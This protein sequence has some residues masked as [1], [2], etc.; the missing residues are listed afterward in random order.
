MSVANPLSAPLRSLSS[1][2]RPLGPF[3]N[4]QTSLFFPLASR[5]ILAA[6]GTSKLHCLDLSDLSLSVWLRWDLFQSP[7][8]PHFP[9]VI[10]KSLLSLTPPAPDQ[11]RIV[12]LSVCNDG[13]LTC[14]DLSPDLAAH[15]H[16]SE[17]IPSFSVPEIWKRSLALPGGLRPQLAAAC[18]LQITA[19]K[20]F[21]LAASLPS[22]VVLSNDGL[23][24]VRLETNHFPP[25]KLLPLRLLRLHLSSIAD[26]QRSYVSCHFVSHTQVATLT[27]TAGSRDA[28]SLTDL[29]FQDPHL[30]KHLTTTNHV[31]ASLASVER[32]SETKLLVAH[33]CL[34][35]PPCGWVV[36]ERSTGGVLLFNVRRGRTF[37]R[38][39]L[40]EGKNPSSRS[41]VRLRRL[42]RLSAQ[43]ARTL[44][45]QGDGKQMEKHLLK[46]TLVSS[47]INESGVISCCV[48]KP[49]A[50]IVI[51]ISPSA[52][53][54]DFQAPK[55]NSKTA[56]EDRADSPEPFTAPSINVHTP[57]QLVVRPDVR[58]APFVTA[59]MKLSSAQRRQICS[60]RK[61]MEPHTVPRVGASG[62][63]IM[64]VSVT[65]GGSSV[66]S[67]P[68]SGDS[69]PRLEDGWSVLETK[70]VL[71][72]KVGRVTC[73]MWQSRYLLLGCRGHL[74]VYERRTWLLRRVYRNCLVGPIAHIVSVYAI[75]P[76]QSLF[77]DSDQTPKNVFHQT[78]T[79]QDQARVLVQSVHGACALLNLSGSYSADTQNAHHAHG[80]SK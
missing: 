76:S 24:V 77:K 8:L 72:S 62:P 59:S 10:L 19:L 44:F 73:A 28:V 5:F 70:L 27:R 22:L 13:L 25:L 6:S 43:S 7:T 58:P 39:D 38:T 45:R 31:D 36:L 40:Q 56:E 32:V 47:P 50:T 4:D 23:H 64:K 14:W 1:L 15:L 75:I 79:V 80:R 63:L 54:A 65:S 18:D 55:M 34:S 74:C 42:W 57:V 71:P 33:H 17:Y 53:H 2:T 26:M 78:E 60:H 16:A 61:R 30:S 69:N 29:S 3:S 41:L 49:G 9:G 52:T 46:T 20:I 66:P 48:S 11:S 21:D 67:I 37:S 35:C 12:A 51:S 68:S